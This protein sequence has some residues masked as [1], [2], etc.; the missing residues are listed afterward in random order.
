MTLHLLM[1]KGVEPIA[2]YE[3]VCSSAAPGRRCLQSVRILFVFRLDALAWSVIA[4]ATWLGG[5]VA[6]CHSRYCIKTNKPIL[7]LFG[8]SGSPII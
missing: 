5:W 3:H 6:L 1:L 7:E 2:S 4:M 8:P